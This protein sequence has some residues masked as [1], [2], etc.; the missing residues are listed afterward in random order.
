MLKDKDIILYSLKEFFKIY[1]KPIIDEQV[2][3]KKTFPD[4]HW[5]LNMLYK[6][7]EEGIMD[8]I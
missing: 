1:V 8:E 3:K 2:R 7:K 5:L 6:L 4:S